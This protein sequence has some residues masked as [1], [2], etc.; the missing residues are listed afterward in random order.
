LRFVAPE[1]SHADGVYASRSSSSEEADFA[2]IEKLRFTR[3][4]QRKRQTEF[5]CLFRTSDNHRASKVARSGTRKRVIHG[6]AVLEYDG[7]FQKIALH[8]YRLNERYNRFGRD[9]PLEQ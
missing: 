3:A 8:H 2:A 6:N 5:R 7:C 9:N 4:Y 1:R